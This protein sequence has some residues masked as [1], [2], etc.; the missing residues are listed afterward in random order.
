[1]IILDST[2][3]QVSTKVK[4]ELDGFKDYKRETYCEVIGKLIELVKED[5]ESKMQ[6]SEETLKD[7]KEAEQDIKKGKVYTTAQI[8]RELGI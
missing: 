3:I 7:I 6:L 8:K 4:R 1:M 2:T 5:E